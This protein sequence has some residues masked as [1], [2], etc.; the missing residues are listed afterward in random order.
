MFDFGKKSK[1][2]LANKIWRIA[3]NAS[4]QF[5]AYLQEDSHLYGKCINQNPIKNTS[6]IFVVNLYRDLL[7]SKYDS[8]DVFS[9]IRTTMLTLAPDKSADDLFMRSFMD[10]MKACNQSIEYY[11]QFPNFD[12]IDVLTKVYFS[13]VIDDRE[14]LQK[15]L[16][17][18]I[19]Q[20]VSYRKIYNYISGI[21]KHST[22]LNEEYRL[23]LR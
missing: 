15:E 19:P 10:Y 14:Y 16:E 7:N 18:S 12:A 13:L 22:L 17:A 11:K 21:S 8:K 5:L 23:K 6:A 9:V 4:E 2:E 3:V 20:S 1:T